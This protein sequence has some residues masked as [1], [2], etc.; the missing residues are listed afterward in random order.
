MLYTAKT[1][2]CNGR[3]VD[4]SQAQ[5]MG[6]LNLTPDSFYDGGRYE[7]ET[8]L[9]Q[10]ENMLGE[11]ADIID[12]G[13][14]SSRPGA[15]LVSLEDERKRVIPVIRSILKA[16]PEAILSI[17][18]VRSEI[19]K[20]AYACGVGIIN[21]ISASKVDSGMYDILGQLKV[22]YVLMHMQGLPNN[23]QQNPNYSNVTK[24]VL[25]F[26]IE[27]L[28][29]LKAYNPTDVIIDPGF[30]FGKT[31]EHNYE[32]LKNLG[33][34]KILECPIMVGISRKSMI[35]KVTGSSSEEALNGTTA[36]HMLALQNGADI[37]RVHDVKEA[38][39]VRK[40]YKA[41]TSVQEY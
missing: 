23:M 35:S 40:L 38:V 31:V 33:L 22:P 37:L 25:D 3:I 27:E 24:E 10:V 4:L 20:E 18:T 15:E 34:F 21:D 32:L 29:K 5:I 36:L 2:N 8:A 28:G 9:R 19:A 6:I 39:E 13:G 7:G 17:D 12:I 1:L 41:Y 30:G 11:G 14:M 16:F 26:L